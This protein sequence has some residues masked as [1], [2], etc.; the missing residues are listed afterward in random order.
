[1]KKVA[2]LLLAGILAFLGVALARYAEADDAPG[3]V[4]MG[5]LLILGALVVGFKGLLV[6]RSGQPRA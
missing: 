2:M 6:A 1:M 3:G 5:W 4:V